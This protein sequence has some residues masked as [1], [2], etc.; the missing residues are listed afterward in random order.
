MGIT[1][2]RKTNAGKSNIGKTN[3]SITDSNGHSMKKIL[4]LPLL[5]LFLLTG[6]SGGSSPS[7]ASPDA[8]ESAEVSGT[9]M[10]PGAP[11]AEALF[12]Q[13]YISLSLD[14]PDSPN[15]IKRVT[16]DS[17]GSKF[18]LLAQYWDREKEIYD[19]HDTLYIFDGD[20]QQLEPQ[21]FSLELPDQS[22]YYI[23]SLEVRSEQELSFRLGRQDGNEE[24]ELLVITDME[25][26]LLSIEEDFPDPES[27]PWNSNYRD[28]QMALDSPDGSTIVCRWNENEEKSS[29]F[30]F[31][32][33]QGSRSPL[34]EIPGQA[35]SALYLDSRD[36]LYYIAEGSLIRWNLTD[37]TRQNL[38][39][40]T[41]IGISNWP[42][43]LGITFNSQGQAL[44]CSIAD[45]KGKVFVLSEEELQ[46]ADQIRFAYLQED[47][48]RYTI[49]L[50]SA[51]SYEHPQCPVKA[52][53][54]YGTDL[55]DRIFM[56][57]ATGEGPELM[58]VDKEDMRTL[59]E[60]EL[61]M[62]LTDVIPPEIYEQLF[63][64]VIQDG[65]VNG[66]MVGISPFFSIESMAVPNTVWEGDSWTLPDLLSVA[67]EREDWNLLL[68]N[69]YLPS[70]YNLFRK[71]L[72]SLVN[73]PF[74]DLEQGK[75]D[76]RH[77]DFARLLKL[78]M[79]YG[80]PYGSD[81]EYI[82]WN[83]VGQLMHAGQC[84]TQ[85]SYFNEGFL[86]FS[87][88]M[89]DFGDEIHMV[90]F[91]SYKDSGHYM[92]SPNGYL[93]VNKNA[94]HPEEIREYLALLLDYDSQLSL[95][96]NCNVR[97]DVTRDQ[98]Q[99]NFDGEPVF[100]TYTTSYGLM[101]SEIEDLKPDGTTYIEEYMEFLENCV[102]WPV[103]P[104]R[105]SAILSEELAGYFIGAK[106]LEDTID[107]LQN[108]VQLYLD[109][110][111]K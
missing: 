8:Q 60:K 84:V 32:K 88:I 35:L 109:E 53:N 77:E 80:N 108:R 26:N 38:S 87:S 68:A 86:E 1:D 106:S 85:L 51:F 6:C 49:K 94:R 42:Q 107:V 46:T 91:P 73:T 100:V 16:A 101:Q 11:D 52:E 105:I 99:N 89:A 23:N 41:D 63:S 76:F 9:E 17:Y 90:G 65:T 14:F 75:A 78:C 79:Q 56:E 71:L 13:K 50:S 82:G 37:D 55:N 12:P 102:P 93:V 4:L 92:S 67:E 43:Y 81:P 103:E 36:N 3:F 10:M 18:Y 66:T 29:L 47:L 111:G 31:D 95:N 28:Y 98:I 62:D 24:H 22:P 40:L 61:L 19:S 58:W 45:A 21:P 39:R 57:L 15:Y 70:N 96:W 59:A 64:C 27:Y 25:G 83:E 110:G 104:S 20:T 48:L 72:P 54:I 30:W 74:L 5:S 7:A 34:G 2:M 69:P 33:G 44:V 97:K